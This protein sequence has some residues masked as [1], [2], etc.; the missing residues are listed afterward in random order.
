MPLALQSPV[1][2]GVCGLSRNSDAKQLSE[3]GAQVMTRYP[4]MGSALDREDVFNRD[5]ADT[6]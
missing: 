1:L 6:I 2:R 3:I 4:A 5:A